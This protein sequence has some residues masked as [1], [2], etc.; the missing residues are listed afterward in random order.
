[1]ADD[2]LYNHLREQ[3]WRR[4]LTPAEQ[5]QLRAWLAKHPGVQEDWDAESGLEN[6]LN[7][8]PNVPVPSNFTARVLQAVKHDEAVQAREPSRLWWR[9]PRLLLPRA[10][11]AALVLGG[12]ALSYHEFETAHRARLAQS[13]VAVSDVSSLPSPEILTNYD[14]ILCLNQTP[15]ADEHLLALL[16]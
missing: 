7:R 11:I 14:A 3:R 8:V 13:V 16:K 9:L 1:M 2:P 4:L 15:A 5:E 6:L 10:A 12:G